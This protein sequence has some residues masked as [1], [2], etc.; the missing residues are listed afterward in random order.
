VRA[1]VFVSVREKGPVEVWLTLARLPW[2][3]R[4][5]G[6]SRVVDRDRSGERVGAAIPIGG[7]GRATV[8]LTGPAV[9]ELE[10]R[11]ISGE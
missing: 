1:R 9:A 8:R 2:S 6:N 4:S 11:P 3:G 5:Y 10:V 7:D